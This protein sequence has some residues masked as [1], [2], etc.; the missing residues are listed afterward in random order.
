MMDATLSRMP[1]YMAASTIVIIGAIYTAGSKR[2]S[3]PLALW[4]VTLLASANFDPPT[5]A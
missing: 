3:P 5:Q 2:D 4:Q 1:W